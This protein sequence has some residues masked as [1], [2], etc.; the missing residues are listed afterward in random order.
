[1]F[2]DWNDYSLPSDHDEFNAGNADDASNNS[3]TLFE[4]LVQFSNRYFPDLNLSSDDLAKDFALNGVLFFNNFETGPAQADPKR[5]D[6]K[7]LQENQTL[8]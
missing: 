8:N 5:A 4:L 7:R 1:M 3:Q 2:S 6:R